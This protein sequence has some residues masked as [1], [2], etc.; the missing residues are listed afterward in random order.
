M[1]FLERGYGC[2]YDRA[3]FIGKA[4]IY[5]NMT[6]RHVAL[7]DKT[8]FGLLAFLVPHVQSHATNE[9][10]TKKGWMGIGA[11]DRYVLMTKDGRPLTFKDLATIP[12]DSLREKPNLR[13]SILVKPFLVI[14]G[15][16]SR[17]GMFHGNNLPAPEINYPDFIKYNFMSE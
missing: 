16:Y 9:V 13:K 11:L 2:C 6:T 7:Y 10:F 5:Y 15:L 4:L 14:Y 12:L 8:N 3:R 17:H 1:D